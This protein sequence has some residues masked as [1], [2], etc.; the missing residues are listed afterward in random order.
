MVMYSRNVLPQPFI[1]DHAV[2]VGVFHVIQYNAELSANAAH[3][4]YARHN[5]SAL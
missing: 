3:R 4:R 5:P 1:H 2:D